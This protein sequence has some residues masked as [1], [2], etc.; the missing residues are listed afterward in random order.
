MHLDCIAYKRLRGVCVGLLALILLV[1]S[2]SALAH[3][4]EYR[5]ERGEAVA[6][7]FVSDHDGPIVNAGFRVFAPDGRAIF[8]R[9]RTDE[10]GRAIFM[11]D[12]SGVWKLVLATEDGHGA[13]VEISFDATASVKRR[14]DDSVSMG[15][16]P[17][18]NSLLSAIGYLLGVAGLLLL[19]RRRAS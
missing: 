11:P 15:R 17:G 16:V 1:I 14:V 3:G 2:A 19:W 18:L 7:Y 9:G 6:V 5:I 8:V 10:L 12:R 13:E 4:L